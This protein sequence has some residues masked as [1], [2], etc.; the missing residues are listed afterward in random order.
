MNSAE[1]FFEKLKMNK[2]IFD[3]YKNLSET[4][5]RVKLID[6]L[7]IDCLNWDEH[8]IIR[9]ESYKD[10]EKT[11]YIDYKF[12]S[13]NNK[14]LVEA[15]KND[16]YFELPNNEHKLYKSSGIL[17]TD[18]KL[19]KAFEQAKKY[20]R[21]RGINVGC[22]TNGLQYIVF[23]ITA[24]N[25]KSD[26]YCFKSIDDI[27]SNIV[28]FYNI[29][30]QSSNAQSVLEKLFNLDCI[31]L[32]PSFLKSVI[33]CMPDKNETIARNSIDSQ[34]RIILNKYFGN[35][36]SNNLNML[37]ECYCSEDRYLQYEKQMTELLIDRIPSLD[38]PVQKSKHFH[39]DFLHNNSDSKSMF[40]ISTVMVIVGGV[41]SG[42]T[43]F[44][45]HF[46]NITIKKQNLSNLIWLDIDFTKISKENVEAIDIIYTEVL[47]QLEENYT[48]L[49]LNHWDTIK[50]IYMP[51]V[52]QLQNGILNPYYTTNN[53]EYE[54]KLSDILYNEIKNKIEYCKK[55]LKYIERELN[56]TICLVIDNADQ[57]SDDFQK[58]TLLAAYEFSKEHKCI[59][60]ISM[61]EESYWKFKNIHPLD[62]YQGCA[63]HISAPHVS[64]LL[65]KRIAYAIK[66]M[67][68]NE[69]EFILPNGIVAK[70]SVNKFFSMVK[71]SLEASDDTLM[72]IELFEALSS[73]NMRYATDI[74]QIFLTSGH[75]NT[76]E[77]ISYYIEHGKYTIPRHAFIR[78]I[79]LGDYKYYHSDKS[80]VYN[81]LLIDEDGF[82]SHFN[83]L[84]ILRYLYDNMYLESLSGKGFVKISDM[85]KVFSIIYSNESL[86]RNSLEIL[87]QYRLIQVDKGFNTMLDNAEYVKITSSGFYYLNDLF[88]EFSYIER[89]L[90]DTPIANLKRYQSIVGL[91][92][93]LK[94][95]IDSNASKNARMHA[96]RERI[97]EFLN[98]LEEE[99]KKDLSYLEDSLINYEFVKYSKKNIL[100]KIVP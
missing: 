72:N 27:L 92:H 55:V 42:K 85:Y 8:N 20:C 7:F 21:D 99:E 17:L 31:R 78:S 82:Y 87:M 46:Y 73:N 35:L 33:D 3:E 80:N 56:K 49:N 100:S 2:N 94:R 96:R 29:F 9:E 54:K 84:R 83:K 38:T 89:L 98:Y 58:K 22:I 36:S 48:F 41:G 90:E 19:K 91:T 60:L 47:E 18:T 6:F 71:S 77:Y 67:G 69:I 12:E 5:T 93:N 66:E 37:E 50:K 28:I 25:G 86:F 59:T 16:L 62:A 53:I 43:T 57:K 10:E 76:T 30:S 64:T 44:L 1:E 39:D 14:F 68:K 88:N 79:A 13:N 15:K 32:K 95:L 11:L 45:E 51:L 61:R 75:T 40:G 63:Y 97:M 4:D 81:I 34:I 70:I 26:I 52:I 65:A 23:S 74:F 24:I